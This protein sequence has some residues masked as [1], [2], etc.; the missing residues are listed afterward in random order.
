VLV[1]EHAAE[2]VGHGVR[3]EPFEPG[4]GGID[5]MLSVEQNVHARKQVA[6]GF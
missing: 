6:R 3:L 5:S 2:R 1:H 4:L